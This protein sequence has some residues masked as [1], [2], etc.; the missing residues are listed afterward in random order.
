MIYLVLFFLCIFIG[1]V[2]YLIY[3]KQKRERWIKNIFQT[4]DEKIMSKKKSKRVE[5]FDTKLMQSGL[6]YKD[7]KEIVLVAFL[8]SFSLIFLAIFMDFSE[9]VSGSIVF[10]AVIL[11]ILIPF[12]YIE[13]QIKTRQKKIEADLSVFLDLVVIILEGGGGLNNAI[14]EVAS[15]GELVIGKEL[16]EEVEIFKNELISYGSD[17]A[18]ENFARR[19]GSEV[20]ATLVGFM[21][22]SEETGIG[23]KNV[24]ENQAQ[25]IKDK[26]VVGIEKKAAMMNVNMTFTMFLFILPAVI[27]MIA[28]PMSSMKIL[29]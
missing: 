6:K 1:S 12:L 29:P 21:K 9:L 4:E 23:V 19:T 27:A 15:S 14:D 16:L 25:E 5:E 13:E 28:F 22:L 3:I 20:V 8:T 26:E 2:A 24:F 10:I 18:Y 7:I 17:I 11:P